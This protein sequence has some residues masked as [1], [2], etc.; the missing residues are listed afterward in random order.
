MMVFIK[1]QEKTAEEADT[2]LKNKQFVYFESIKSDN[3][4]TLLQ[5]SLLH[6]LMSHRLQPTVTFSMDVRSPQYGQRKF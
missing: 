4:G 3:I 1:T 2:F 5:N 6:T